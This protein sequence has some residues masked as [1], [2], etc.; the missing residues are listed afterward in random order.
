MSGNSISTAGPAHAPS[1]ASTLGVEHEPLAAGGQEDRLEPS[2]VVRRGPSTSLWLNIGC[3]N[4]SAPN[5]ASSSAQT[6]RL[7]R[8]ERFDSCP[9]SGGRSGCKSSRRAPSIRP[10]PPFSYWMGCW[11][12]RGVAGG[13]SGRGSTFHGLRRWTLARWTDCASPRVSPWLP[14]HQDLGVTVEAAELRC[15]HHHFPYPLSIIEPDVG[16]GVLDGPSRGPTAAVR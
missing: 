15:A 6:S 5:R 14:Q 8:G 2:R 9:A 13:P 7:T 12:V 11:A 16:R 10:A 3:H 4:A 1:I